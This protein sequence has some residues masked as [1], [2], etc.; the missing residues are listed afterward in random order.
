MYVDM[1]DS[2]WGETKNPEF[3]FEVQVSPD[4]FN[5][6]MMTIWNRFHSLNGVPDEFGWLRK[7]S[8]YEDFLENALMRAMNNVGK[9]VYIDFRGVYEHKGVSIAVKKVGPSEY[10]ISAYKADSGL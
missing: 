10:T 6:G 9:F 4:K 8:S 7:I 5:D 2:I 1:K 3:E